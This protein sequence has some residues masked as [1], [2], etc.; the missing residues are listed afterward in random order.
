MIVCWRSV[1]VPPEQRERFHA[2]ILENRA[3][4]EQ[5]GLL[6]ELVLDRSAI[7]NPPKTRQPTK[8][9]AA[10]APEQV[11][12]T[13]WASH[14][15]FDAWI[16]TPDR[17]RLTASDVHQAVHYGPI[18]RYDTTGGYLNLLALTAPTQDQL[19]G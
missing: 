10:S 14:A 18:T 9:E 3:V 4:R 8:D 19:P 7:Q 1:H 17:D 2:W 6:F 15:A 11:V 5:H 13:A 16:N 12:I